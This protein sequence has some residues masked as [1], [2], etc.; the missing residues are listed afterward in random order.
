MVFKRIIRAKNKK[1]RRESD[2]TYLFRSGLFADIEL[3]FFH[4]LLKLKN[5]LVT[6]APV[7]LRTF[8]LT[9]R[10]QQPRR[11]PAHQSPAGRAHHARRDGETLRTLHFREAC[12]HGGHGLQ[13]SQRDVVIITQIG[14]QVAGEL[15]VET[16]RWDGLRLGWWKTANQRATNLEAFVLHVCTAENIIHIF[17]RHRLQEVA[18]LLL[19]LEGTR[20]G[21]YYRIVW[22]T[23]YS[24][25]DLCIWI[26]SRA[27][28]AGRDFS[29]PGPVGASGRFFSLFLS[30][31]SGEWEV[32]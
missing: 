8:V 13:A 23:D 32:P 12:G 21:R 1:L 24:A 7:R 2:D 9:T 6:V 14:L 27:E 20:P 30:F 16:R 5:V 31:L 19:S 10:R 17:F 3:L 26:M 15:R 22:N 4:P 25:S 28:R 29:L 18:Y 11:T